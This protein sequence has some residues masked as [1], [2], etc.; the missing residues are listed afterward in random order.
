VA[1]HTVRDAPRLISVIV[2]VL[3]A[4]AVLPAQLAAFAAQTYSRP[5]ELL[6]ADNGS[7]DDV[8]GL[9]R[10]WSHRLPVRVVDASARRG[11]NPA[12]NQARA[13]AVGDLLA[14]C[15]AD[16]EVSPRWLDEL[17]SAARGFDVVGGR[18]DEESLNPPS[19]A[20]RPRLPVDRLP[21]ALGFLPFAHG[22]N[23]AIWADVLDALGGFD[24]RFVHGYDEV[25]FCFRAQ[26][27]GYHLGHAP[28]AVIAY[29][30]RGGER[31]L[32][33]QFRSY[34]RAE[35]LLYRCFRDQGMD[36]PSAAEVIKRWARIGLRAARRDRVSRGRW[37]VEA[38]FSL[39]RLEGAV[40]H[41]VLYL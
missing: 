29:R 14:F 4:A 37:L 31:G 38:G 21:V 15:D 5:W 13:D 10:G 2:P 9:V 20:H 39:G 36:R 27:A 25:E 16:D 35:P 1:E 41:R 28:D 40:R 12:R 6:I 23:W 26:L 34:G 19:V 18:L 32:F 7:T 33:D 3:D 17:A 24:E 30:H 22:A 8:R 11:I